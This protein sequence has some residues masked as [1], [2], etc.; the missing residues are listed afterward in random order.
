MSTLLPL[1]LLALQEWFIIYKDE[2]LFALYNIVY[3][4][5]RVWAPENGTCDL[6]FFFL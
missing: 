3:F 2:N 1:R 5:H 4:V 6:F